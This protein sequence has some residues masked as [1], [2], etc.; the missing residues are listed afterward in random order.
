MTN[1]KRQIPAREFTGHK[2]RWSD[3][4][5]EVS[6]A[7]TESEA[8]FIE[9]RTSRNEANIDK[10]IA[11]VNMLDK[12]VRLEIAEVRAAN[13]YII[14]T[15]QLLV[16]RKEFSPVQVLVYVISGSAVCGLILFFILR[17]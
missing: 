11:T 13:N 8:Q 12:D 1:E 7:A 2:K 15:L 6:V 16:T 9:R 5:A 14:P 3:F 10:V 4:R 17:R